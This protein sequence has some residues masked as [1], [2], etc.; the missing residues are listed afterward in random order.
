[1]P[2]QYNRDFAFARNIIFPIRLQ[3][4]TK[5]DSSLIAGALF[6]RTLKEVEKDSAIALGLEKTFYIYSNITLLPLGPENPP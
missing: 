3:Y 1:M 6:C 4:L 2:R 5:I